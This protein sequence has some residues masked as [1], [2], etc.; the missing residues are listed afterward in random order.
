MKRCGACGDEFE[1]HLNFC[2][3]D[4][5]PLVT[6]RDVASF[7]Y[8]P[9]IISDESLARRLAIQFAFLVSEFAW[10]GHG[11]K[12]IHL[13]SFRTSSVSS[14]TTPDDL[15]RDHTFAMAYSSQ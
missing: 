6:N 14:R 12:L 15:S 2:P 11:S 3:T 4:G 13:S 9:T 5:K 1:N 10:R 8:R 7:D